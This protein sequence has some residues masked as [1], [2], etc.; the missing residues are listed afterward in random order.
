MEVLMEIERLKALIKER[1]L[2][3]A[4]KPVFKLS[5]GKLSPYYIDLKQITFLP[6]GMADP[7]SY[8]IA[9]VSLLD[10]NPLK[11][12]VVRKEKKEHGTGK[13]IEGVLEKGERVAV[14]EDVIT[15]GS[16][17]LKAVKAC[18]EEGLEVIGVFAIV[19]REEGGKENIEKEGIK[20]Y[21]LLTLKELL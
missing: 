21:S 8:S 9:F 5:S 13:R 4:D 19:D 1:S 18:L 10:N 6:E 2:K 17:S 14:V 16:S 11:P 7:I 12:F 15:T 3:V 20:L